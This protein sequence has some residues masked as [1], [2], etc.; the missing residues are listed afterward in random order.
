M[1]VK[2]LDLTPLEAARRFVSRARE[3]G[4]KPQ[5]LRTALAKADRVDKTNLQFYRDPSTG[6]CS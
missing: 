5:N 4:P 2:S 1:N 3:H 6:R